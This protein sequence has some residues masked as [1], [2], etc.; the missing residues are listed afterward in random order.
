V[1]DAAPRSS[2][3]GT[4]PAP[5][6][7]ASAELNLAFDAFDTVE[8][9]AAGI[10]LGVLGPVRDAV[11][12]SLCHS[13]ERARDGALAFGA[14]RPPAQVAACVDMAEQF[15]M[16]VA[17]TSDAQRAA[18]T[19]ALGSET[20]LF[21]QALYVVDVFQRARI[22]LERLHGRSY[23]ALGAARDGDLWAAL[24]RFMRVVAG[25]DALDPLTTEL[26]R[27][28]GATAHQCRLCQSR[29][30]LRAVEHA[31]GLDA[32]ERVRDDSND[33]DEHATLAL[34]LTDAMLLQPT[35]IDDAL[36]AQTGR[37][38][39]VAESTEVVLDVARNAANKIAVALAADGAHVSDGVEFFDLDGTGEVV[40]DADP[41]VVRAA[42]GR[43]A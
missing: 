38:L 16:D 6:R 28:R 3:G 41:A 26:V 20:F 25:L 18:V 36:V 2:P 37:V 23:G 32:F 10:D 22:T 35:R 8:A 27:L 14:E 40:A 21:V 17:A 15:V 1:T 29:R 4:A 31:G 5:W 19:D 33:P 30:S 7:A 11:A 13:D 24:D 9:I 39:S 43:L 12:A 42:T 34:R